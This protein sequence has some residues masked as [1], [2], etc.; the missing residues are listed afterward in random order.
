MV[1][2]RVESVMSR[3]ELVMLYC[4]SKL[5]DVFNLIKISFANLLLRNRGDD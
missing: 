1:R 4:I 2:G 3:S 5:V